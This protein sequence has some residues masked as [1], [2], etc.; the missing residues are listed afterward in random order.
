MANRVEWFMKQA[1]QVHADEAAKKALCNAEKEWLYANNTSD[2]TVAKKEIPRY[3]QALREAGLVRGKYFKDYEE[4]W[5]LYLSPDKE[6]MQTYTD[7]YNTRRAERVSGHQYPITNAQALTDRALILLESETGYDVIAGLCLLT[8]RREAEI[9]ITANIRLYDKDN[10]HGYF[11]GQL[12]GDMEKRDTQMLIPIFGDRTKV[13][14][15]LAWLRHRYPQWAAR[16]PAQFDADVASDVRK[17]CKDWFEPLFPRC[18]LSITAHALRKAYAAL[19]NHF[20]DHAGWSDEAYISRIMGHDP[21]DS[22]SVRSY[23]YFYVKA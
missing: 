21:E 18:E 12:K 7:D 20:C 23:Q 2:L 9:G 3:K 8:G 11:R 19:A 1:P 14:Q 15:A 13:C 4:T 17:H 10:I 16:T 6:K 22:Y 5:L